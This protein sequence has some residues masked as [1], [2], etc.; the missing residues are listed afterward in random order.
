MIPYLASLMIFAQEI[1][2]TVPE[3]TSGA[4]ALNVTPGGILASSVAANVGPLLL[5][6]MLG[7]AK[8]KT[9]NRK[10]HGWRS[11]LTSV[12]FGIAGGAVEGKLSG[13]PWQA[14]L[15]NSAVGF[16]TATLGYLSKKHSTPTN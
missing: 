8:T 16:G 11:L 13:L 2:P 1:T 15:A 5:K 6:M 4:D 7:E 10:L 9:E 3:P 14:A 12:A